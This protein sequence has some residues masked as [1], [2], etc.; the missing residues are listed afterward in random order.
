[1]AKALE[2]LRV[3]DLTVWFQGPVAAQ[4]LADFGAEV[5]KVERPQ[6]GDQGR[7][8]RPRY[9]TSQRRGE[10]CE[11]PI[12]FVEPLNEQQGIQLDQRERRMPT[13]ILAKVRGEKGCR[14]KRGI[15]AQNDHRA[16][17]A[18]RFSVGGYGVPSDFLRHVAGGEPLTD[19]R[20]GPFEVC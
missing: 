5:I 9:L 20:T 3:I 18:L 12:A 19:E 13:P 7:R 15:R 16:T 2:G 1:V 14:A 6:G 4:Y 11:S 10:L 17:N 8:Q